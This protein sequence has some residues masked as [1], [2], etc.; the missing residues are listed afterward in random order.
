MRP[1]A[2]GC[3]L[4]LAQDVYLTTQSVE[5]LNAAVSPQ[6]FSETPDCV[7]GVPCADPCDSRCALMCMHSWRRCC[8]LPK[9]AK[10]RRQPSPKRQVRTSAA[11]VSTCNFQPRVT[12]SFVCGSVSIQIC[13]GLQ[14]QRQRSPH[15]FCLPSSCRA[16]CSRSEATTPSISCC[17]ALGEPSCLLTHFPLV[18]VLPVAVPIRSGFLH[19]STF[20]CVLWC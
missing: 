16:G 6:S 12:R 11:P 4:W 15:H 5:R 3:W 9:R 14:Q 8:R 13:V 2:C 17:A 19:G 20:G 10:S 7:A 18:L 1:H